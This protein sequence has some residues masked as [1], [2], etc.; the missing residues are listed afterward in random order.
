MK[1]KQVIIF[2]SFLL[3][4]IVAISVYAQSPRILTLEESINIALGQSFDAAR[5][6]QSLINSEM[7][8]RAAQAG[9][10]S[11]SELVLSRLPNYQDN[12]RQT[13][14]SGGSF[15]FDRQKFLDMQAELYIN[16]PIKL[17]DGVVSLVGVF[18]RFQQYGR[19]PKRI[20]DTIHI[21]EDPIEYS[22]QLR[23]RFRQPLFTLNRLSTEF[24]KAELNLKK[25]QQI[26][27]RTQLDI[28]HNVTAN[29]YNL[30]RAQKQLEIDLAQVEQSE[31]AYRIAN[32]KQQAGLLP[33]VEVLRLEVDLADAR[34]RAAASEAS[35]QGTEDSF[36]QLIGLPI[37]ESVQ[38]TTILTYKIIDVT[39]EKAMQE[40]LKRRTELRTDEIDLELSTISVKETDA[41]REIKGELNISYGIFQ[42]DSAFA[43][44][45]KNF[46]DDRSVTL[47]L[48]IP[49]WDW[50]KNSYQVQAAKANLE[51]NRLTQ[52]NRIETIKQEIR[53]V[54]RNLKSAQ[55]RI[56]ITKRSEELAEKSYQ[57]SLLKFE[58]GDLST[59]DLALEQN[60]LTQARINSLNAIIDY[61]Q[62]LSD[63]RRKTLWDFEKNQPVQNEV[64][65]K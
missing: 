29:F 14:L 17:T 24:H 45:F 3:S 11:N 1:K 59:Q 46:A 34:N 30:F 37:E 63:L 20:E 32:L 27:T 57:I 47:S 56:D 6:E 4:T 18:Q 64:E 39:L 28:I 22:P 43:N 58:N 41:L 7:G 31:N 52:K 62:A 10:K 16:Q 19:I 55:Q 44:A 2:L 15:S 25:T 49:L 12:E 38:A 42:R 54:V 8:L 26:Y 13:A 65:E 60:R 53:A 9:L 40:A 23:L 48:N 36:K 50:N 61:K 33:E 5:L 21:F 35:L 51:S